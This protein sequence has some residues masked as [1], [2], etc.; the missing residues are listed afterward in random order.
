MGADFGRRLVT[1]SEGQALGRH[2]GRLVS[3]PKMPFPGNGERH[4]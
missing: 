2:F 3:S 1:E 4:N